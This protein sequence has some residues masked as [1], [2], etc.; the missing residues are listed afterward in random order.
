MRADLLGC[1]LDLISM[2]DALE[3]IAK[4]IQHGNTTHI[5][6]M[7]AEIVFQAQENPALR[8]IIN[9]A[10]LIT[11]DGIGTVWGA[12]FLGYSV[13]ERVT[14]IDLMLRL[15]VQAS[16]E[17]WKIYLLGAA[18]GVAEIAAQKLINRFPGL[19]V[20]GC[21]DGYF[22]ADRLPQMVSDINEASPQL[23]FVALGA[24]KQEFWIN[25]HRSEFHSIPVYM[26]VGGSLDVIAG[27]KKRAPTIFIR[28]NL[29]WLYRLLSEPSRIKRQLSL[30]RFVWR[31]VKQRLMAG[32]TVHKD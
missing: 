26:G 27:N 10:E 5:I 24:P 3:W 18:P 20:C 2:D 23:L 28:L 11:P 14:G 12:R 25:E 17:G 16:M 13:P 22:T 31:V 8:S 6:T 15:C 1:S 19:Q 29:E 30:P 32:H 9:R 7:N 21:Q 4:R